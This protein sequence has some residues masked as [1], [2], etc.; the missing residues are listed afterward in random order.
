MNMRTLWNRTWD[1]NVTGTQIVTTT[2]IPLLLQS[3]DPRLLF[4]TSGTSSLT[5]TENPKA[6]INSVPEKGWPKKNAAVADVP[7]YRSAKTG[8]NMMMR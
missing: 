5:S 3:A 2:F 1:V 6:P 4:V 8:M 7:A